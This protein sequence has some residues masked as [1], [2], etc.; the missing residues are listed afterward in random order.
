VFRRRRRPEENPAA[1]EHGL[2]DG[3]DD[4]YDDDFDGGVPEGDAPEDDTPVGGASGSAASEGRGAAGEAGGQGPWDSGEGYPEADRVDLGC[5]L[6][7]VGQG[8]DIQ[9]NVVGEHIVAATVSLSGSNLQVQAFAA[10]K[11]GSLWDDLRDE[12]AAE[13]ARH[14]GESQEAE[15]PFGTEL[16]ALVPA[17]AGDQGSSG[18]GS[19]GQAGADRA[20][21][22]PARYLGADG[23]RWVLRGTIIGAAAGDP[24]LAEP[25]EAVFGGIVVVRGDHPAPP[26]DLL[27]IR[28]PEDVQRAVEAAAQ[29]EQ[30]EQAQR[31]REYPNPFDRG[32]EITETR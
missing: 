22:Q 20:G 4:E 12:I 10:P 13:I 26:R 24:G 25:L 9:L 19:T 28:L 17:D 3:P 30:E 2:D 7:P 11:S 21:L 5:L 18:Q 31:R 1:V 32:P 15:G 27:E 14:G 29:A 6:V 23:P 16:R 8:M